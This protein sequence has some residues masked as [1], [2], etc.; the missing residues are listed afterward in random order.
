M[1]ELDVNSD[2]IALFMN[3]TKRV[4]KSTLKQTML[5]TFT[6]NAV[7]KVKLIMNVHYD[8]KEFIVRSLLYG[9][10]KR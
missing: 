2:S 4:F 1:N 9:L 7:K 6:D 10:R 3:E 5:S 8:D